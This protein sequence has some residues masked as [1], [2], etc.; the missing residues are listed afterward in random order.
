MYLTV[1][2]KAFKILRCTQVCCLY[3]IL[4]RHNHLE[5]TVCGWSWAWPHFNNS[6]TMLS[7]K[8]K[9]NWNRSY[10][11]Y[12]LYDTYN[13]EFLFRSLSPLLVI[14]FVVSKIFFDYIYSSI[15]LVKHSV[16]YWVYRVN[17]GHICTSF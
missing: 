13:Y 9:K 17:K 12:T 7:K 1:H 11:I 2:Q 15:Y 6:F 8:K 5:T 3:S 14:Y 4:R 16:G 10:S